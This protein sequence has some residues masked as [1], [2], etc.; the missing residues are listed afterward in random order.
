LF[1]ST[2]GSFTS[3]RQCYTRELLLPDNCLYWYE[4]RGRN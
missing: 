2:V 3:D 4:T 1:F